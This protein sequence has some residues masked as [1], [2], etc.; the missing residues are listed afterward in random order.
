[1]RAIS[2]L[3][4]VPVDEININVLGTASG[5]APGGGS[6]GGGSGG[7]SSGGGSVAQCSSVL[8]WPGSHIYK[9]IGSTHFSPSDVRRNTIGLIVRRGGR[10]PFPSCIRA[11]DSSGTVVA[12]LG[13]Y[14]RNDGWA[15]RYYAGIGCGAS[16]A[17]NGSAVASRAR[18]NTG[19]SNIYMNFDGIC[20]G[21]IDA[22]SCVGS[23]QC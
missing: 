20:F 17:F 12:Q 9:I 2:Y 4:G 7:G 6:G 15:A 14:S 10:G 23:S 19:S 22:G 5:D 16:T 13:L 3:G 11:V 18:A 1:V 8:G 21:P